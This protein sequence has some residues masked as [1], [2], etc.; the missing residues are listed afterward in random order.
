MGIRFHVIGEFFVVKERQHSSWWRVKWC[1]NKIKFLPFLTQICD[2]PKLKVLPTA[3]ACW[4][5]GLISQSH[6]ELAPHVSFAKP[7]LLHSTIVYKDL[8]ACVNDRN[9]L[10]V[11]YLSTSACFTTTAIVHNEAVPCPIMVFL[12]LT[13]Y[14]FRPRQISYR[15]PRIIFVKEEVTPDEELS[16]GSVH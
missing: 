15:F 2:R 9:T 14:M 11:T 1:C 7:R 12:K 8:H 3:F 16:I 4:F 13:D 5:D 10:L 6:R